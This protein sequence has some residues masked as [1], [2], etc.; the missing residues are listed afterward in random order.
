MSTLFSLASKYLFA[1][2]LFV[3]CAGF[4]WNVV[5]FR[6]SY[7]TPFDA[8]YW[9]T[10]FEESQWI[11]TKSDCANDNPHINPT[12]CVWDDAW[13]AQHGS[14]EK[15]EST[16]GDD[17]LYTYAGWLYI[18]G[19]DPTLFNAEMPP[20]GKYLIGAVTFFTGNQNIYALVMGILVL[21][22]FYLLGKEVLRSS[23][24]AMM[25]VLLLSLEPLFSEQLKATYLDLQHLFFLNL[26]FWAYLT[27]RYFIFS[28]ALGSFAATKFPFLAILVVAALMFHLIFKKE[29]KEL[30]RFL[31]FVFVAV[32]VYVL[33]YVRFFY[34]GHG[35]IEFLKVQKWILSF[36]M[37]GTVNFMRGM[38]FPL[39]F[40]G[41][42]YVWWGEMTRIYE[43]GYHWIILTLVP[44]VPFLA[45]PV[46]RG[47][48]LLSI[49][50]V[51][52]LVF[53]SFTPVWPRYLLLFLPFS[54]LCL[55]WFIERLRRYAKTF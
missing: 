17:G 18:N 42:W 24:W 50:S 28:L 34:L 6:E 40:T 27:R 23:C 4:L 39:L 3:T 5:R 44:L 13:Y 41:R 9:K 26:V 54:Y 43:W 49:W 22:S 25:A 55:M 35:L 21:V 20:A 31:F 1:L 53:L 33:W 37:T 11:T 30:T 16:I 14:R 48:L 52:Y 15:R 29:Y 32:F 45:R 36:Y 7:L 51:F 12:T 47:A 46:S 38:V 10:R 8:A 19:S 2:L